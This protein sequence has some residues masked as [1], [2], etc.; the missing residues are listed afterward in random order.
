MTWVLVCGGRDYTSYQT[1]WREMDAIH[2]KLPI[3]LLITGDAQGADNL[4]DLW[5]AKRGIN[6]VKE[7]AEAKAMRRT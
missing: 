1:I 2:A 4:A 7:V 3:S 6:R 5:A